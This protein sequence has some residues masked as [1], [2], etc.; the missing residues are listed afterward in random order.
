MSGESGIAGAKTIENLLT[1]CGIEAF[2]II[3]I[4]GPLADVVE[5]AVLL[6]QTKNVRGDVF[7]FQLAL[8]AEVGLHVKETV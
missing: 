6:V 7:L 8:H 2:L 1:L 4:E 3:I 5:P